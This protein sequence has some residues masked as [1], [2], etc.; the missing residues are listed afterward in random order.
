M[1]DSILGDFFMQNYVN[2]GY[3]TECKC[4]IFLGKSLLNNWSQQC[5]NNSRDQNDP[6]KNED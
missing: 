6:M 3:N 4:H 1:C 2:Y 5:K